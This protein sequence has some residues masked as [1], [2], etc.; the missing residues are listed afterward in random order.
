MFCIPELL[1]PLI[2][3][4][5]FGAR[6]RG[7]G[8]NTS[9]PRH[10]LALHY[11]SKDDPFADTSH[12]GPGIVPHTFSYTCRQAFQRKAVRWSR[13]QVD[14]NIR[15][16]AAIAVDHFGNSAAGEPHQIACAHTEAMTTES[17][18]ASSDAA[19]NASATT[20]LASF[21]ARFHFE[22]PSGSVTNLMSRRNE[23]LDDDVGDGTDRCKNN[24]CSHCLPRWVLVEGAREP[25]RLRDVSKATSCPAL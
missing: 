16:S 10:V 6:H 8:N 24:G 9:K 5:C 18:A 17:P 3:I 1:A 14:R 22:L 21:R 12:L 2:D 23:C 11:G 15:F 4:C 13:G 7:T 20:D 19:S 25:V